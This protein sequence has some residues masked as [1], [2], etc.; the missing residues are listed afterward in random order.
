MFECRHSIQYT[1]P[2]HLSA[3]VYAH[4][5]PYATHRRDFGRRGNYVVHAFEISEAKRTGTFPSTAPGA[6]AEGDSLAVHRYCVLFSVTPRTD[7]RSMDRHQKKKSNPASERG[8]SDVWQCGRRE[9]L[10]CNSSGPRVTGQES[11]PFNF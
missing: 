7:E 10:P 3:H 6:P 9:S 11:L 4:L 5:G 1:P 8:S 2:Y